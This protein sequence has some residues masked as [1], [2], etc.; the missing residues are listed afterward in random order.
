G[1][2]WGDDFAQYI[3]H[4]RNLAEGR[5][6]ARTEYIY[7]PDYP[8]LGPP[9]YPPGTSLLLAPIYSRWGL[10][11]NAMKW[12]MIGCLIAWL[13][14]L[15]ADFRES[16][17]FPICLV[18]LL[19]LGLNN[20]FLN[21]TNVIGSDILFLVFVYGTFLF[22]RLGDRSED[23][24]AGQWVWYCAAAVSAWA[25]FATRTVG[26][27][28]WPAVLIA[29]FIQHR[30]IRPWQFGATALFLVLVVLQSRLTLATRGYFNLLSW[31]PSILVSQG[32]RYVVV[33]AAF[34]HNGFSHNEFFRFAAAI[35]AGTIWIP[36]LMGYAA[37]VYRRVSAREVFV[38]LYGAAL[39]AWPCYQGFRLL[40]PLLP[41]WLLYAWQGLASPWLL[42][43]PRIRRGL[44]AVLAALIICSYG[45]MLLTRPTGP[46]P[47]GIDRAS[48]QELFA[49]VRQYTQPEDVVVFI[50][51]RALALLTGR[52][53][54]VYHA[55]QNDADLWAYFRRIHARALVT[56]ERP[57]A[58]QGTA[59]TELVQFLADFAARN[60]S[61]LTPI[62]HNEDFTLYRIQPVPP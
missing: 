15:A 6:Y 34:W 44:L 17:P 54:S 16:L 26:A 43:R 25:G 19:L 42:R 13:A 38:V 31:S 45:S 8:M 1:H 40:Y 41:L 10:N 48:S 32:I 14:V 36:A 7:N 47:E 61:S 49:A 22:A 37:Q 46:L 23:R 35:V 29:D 57:E 30:R 53:C 4:A 58:V 39:A 2:S 33:S 24:S 18:I 52:A 50:K 59:K 56:V 5:P 20:F 28:L 62:W 27:V 11:W 21:R 9:V 51:P 3:L 55:V 60:R 12:V